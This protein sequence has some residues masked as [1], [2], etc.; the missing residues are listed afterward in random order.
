MLQT[1][2]FARSNPRRLNSAPRGSPSSP[3]LSSSS[4]CNRDALYPMSCPL[5]LDIC[6]LGTPT[7]SMVSDRRNPRGRQPGENH[8]GS[9]RTALQR[10]P[11]QRGA[12][13]RLP[14]GPTSLGSPAEEWPHY[15]PH[16]GRLRLPLFLVALSRRELRDLRGD[17][18]EAQAAGRAIRVRLWN[19][20]MCRDV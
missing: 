15:A 11:A 19:M 18:E 12:R 20:S 10:Q 17:P 7:A 16:G 13:T 2:S 1:T 3:I 5:T 8:R 6:E 4:R 9:A 14:H